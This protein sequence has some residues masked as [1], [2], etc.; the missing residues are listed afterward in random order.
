MEIFLPK[1]F[2][3]VDNKFLMSKY[4]VTQKEY[5][6]IMGKNPSNHKGDNLPV[7]NISWYDAIEY[8][9]KKSLKEG[10]QPV[11]IIAGENTKI[12]LTKNGYRL[13]TEEEWFYAAKGG[14]LSKGY[15][16][17]GSN[18]PD[19]VAWYGSDNPDEVGNS[20]NKTHSVG[21]KKPNE[22]EIYDMSGNVWEWVNDWWNTEQKYRVL[23]GGGFS[24]DD[25]CIQVDDRY[26]ANP[27]DLYNDLGFR[28]V[29]SLSELI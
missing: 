7:E 16:Y 17:S 3:N 25:G 5:T 22:L 28:C 12:D 18:N 24:S 4:L 8:C 20:G 2:V 27:N 26:Y 13:P 23:C 14:S 10:L 19:E 6:E 15:T 21:T 11:Y 9:N 1:N 29:I